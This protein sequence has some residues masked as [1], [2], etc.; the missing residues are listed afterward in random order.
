MNPFDPMKDPTSDISRGEPSES[1]GARETNGAEYTSPDGS[2][3]LIYTPRAEGKRKRRAGKIIVAVAVTAVALSVGLCFVFTAWMAA[4]SL[5]YL[6]NFGILTESGEPADVDTSD[7][8]HIFDGAD[9]GTDHVLSPGGSVKEPSSSETADGETVRVPQ[10]VT[11]NKRPAKRQDANGDG[12]ADVETDAEG[13]VLTSAGEEILTVPTVVAR[14]SAS[15]VEITTETVTQSGYLGQYVTGGA[16]SGVVIAKEGFIVTNHHVVDGATAVT[17]RMS[18][19]AEFPARVVGSD[20]R[21]DIAVLWIDARDYP[22]TVA[23]LGSSFDLV[24]GEDILAIGNPLGSLGGTVTEGMVSATARQILVNHSRMTLLQ[25]SA[26]INPGNSGGGLFNLAGELIGIVNAKV[27]SEEIEGLGFAIPVDTAYEV[28]LELIAHGY[29]R[30][31]PALGFVAVDVTSVQ[32]AVRYFNSMN[33]GVYVYDKSHGV[34][35][36]GDY[37]VAA[38]G[39]KITSVAELSAAIAARAVGDTLELTVYRANMTTN[40]WEKQTLTVTVVEEVPQ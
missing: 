22:L 9:G 2:H 18:D 37:I 35:R 24:V 5:G 10:G 39:H 36:Y 6:L 40:K 33:T 4:T 31:R 21:T 11:I 32:T 30:G 1:Q 23:T 14:V 34:V 19:G 38:D 3:G 8:L 7:G 12:R 15:V 16:G 25:V 27:S 17:V 26:P 28:I 29:V 13:N 20:A